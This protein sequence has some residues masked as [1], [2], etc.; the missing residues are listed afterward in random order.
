VS[1]K[2]FLLPVTV[3]RKSEQN[4]KKCL[5]FFK[6]FHTK[7]SGFACSEGQWRASDRQQGPGL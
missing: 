2:Q 3:K 4:L 1:L 5:V 7:S 6:S